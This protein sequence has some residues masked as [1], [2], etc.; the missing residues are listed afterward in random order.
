M[1]QDIDVTDVVGHDSDRFVV[2]APFLAIMS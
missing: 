1:S 2:L